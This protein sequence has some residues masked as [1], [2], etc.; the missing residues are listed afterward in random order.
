MCP[1][2][3]YHTWKFGRFL[4]KHPEHNC[5]QPNNTIIINEEPN[6]IENLKLAK[7]FR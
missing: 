3:S 6:K 1:L 7:Q 2:I 4:P 5:I